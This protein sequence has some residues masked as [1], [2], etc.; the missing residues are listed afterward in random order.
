MK[1]SAKFYLEKRKGVTKNIPINLNVTYDGKRLEYYTGKRCNLDQ[2]NGEKVVLKKKSVLANDES[3]NDFNADLN[4]IIVATADLFKK[5]DKKKTLPEISLLRTEL[6]LALGKKV[7]KGDSNDIWD[8]FDQYTVEHIG[9]KKRTKQSIKAVMNVLKKFKPDLTFENFD[10]QLIEEFR[11]HLVEVRKNSE[12]TVGQY[13]TN[14]KTFIKYCQVR[15]WTEINPFLKYKIGAPVYGKP[16]YLTLEERDIVFSAKIKNKRDDILRDYFMLQSLL[17]CRIGD[18][19]KLTKSNIVGGN[20]EYIA[21]KTKDENPRPAIVPLTQKAISII[22]KYN[23]PD[24]KLLPPYSKCFMNEDLKLLFDSL[25]IRRIVTIPDKTTRKGK[26]VRLCDIVTTHMA[27]RVFIGGLYKKGVKDA[28]I[29]SMS[30]H[31]KGSKA[32]LR[33]Y[34]VDNEDQKAAMSLIE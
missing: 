33:Y 23:C 13:L 30:G 1:Y 34:D 16:V 17:G 6:K 29:A 11:K 27:R 9:D 7:K 24:G 19:R 12:N 32:F 3:A 5:Y 10:V 31:V 22:N 15:D 18:L 8:R 14:I 25:G 2:W 21:L 20:I 26:Q 28:I 4:R